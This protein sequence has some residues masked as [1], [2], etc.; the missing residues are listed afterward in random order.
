VLVRFVEAKCTWSHAACVLPEY[1]NSMDQDVCFV[2]SLHI[3]PKV[4]DENCR[5]ELENK[6]MAVQLHSLAMGS[7]MQRSHLVP[8]HGDLLSSKPLNPTIK[9]AA[10]AGTHMKNT[11]LMCALHAA[12]L[13]AHRDSQGEWVIPWTTALSEQARRATALARPT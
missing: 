12:F 11:A 10:A 3:Q 6:A 2:T 1:S 13:K 5:A 9:T 4:D 7:A 8:A